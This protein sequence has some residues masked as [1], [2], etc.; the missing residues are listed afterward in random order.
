M[1]W[2]FARPTTS[3]PTAE[4]FPPAGRCFSRAARRRWLQKCVSNSG[5]DLDLSGMRLSDKDAKVIGNALKKSASIQTLNLS[6]N[7]ISDAGAAAMADAL[8]ENTTLQELDLSGNDIGNE[9]GTEV[10]LDTPRT[11]TI[12]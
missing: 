5:K 1:M 12:A 6:V 9:E 7:N 10:L 11:S 3:K 8:K 2:L 4:T